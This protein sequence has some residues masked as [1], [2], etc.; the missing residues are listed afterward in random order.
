[1]LPAPGGW[2]VTRLDAKAAARLAWSLAALAIALQLAGV[3][4][5][6]TFGDL[7]LAGTDGFK[8]E[9]PR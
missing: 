8:R 9:T 3:V 1:M 4:Q 2:A 7:Q 5:F 6:A